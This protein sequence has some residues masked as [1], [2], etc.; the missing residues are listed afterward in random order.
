MTEADFHYTSHVHDL[1]SSAIAQKYGSPSTLRRRCPETGLRG[2]AAAERQHWGRSP[3]RGLRD[4]VVGARVDATSGYHVTQPEL[5]WPPFA[6]HRQ[7]HVIR[8]IN[9]YS[10]PSL[11]L[12]PMIGA[13]RLP[14]FS[15]Q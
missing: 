14:D 10:T 3:R 7:A 2:D 6:G 15:R 5:G 12:C 11:T 9:T 4:N 1:E 13:K 8:N